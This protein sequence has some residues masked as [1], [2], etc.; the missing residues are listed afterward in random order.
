LWIE[1]SLKVLSKKLLLLI[2]PAFVVSLSWFLSNALM[3]PGGSVCNQDQFVY[4]Q[5]P[6]EMGFSF[7][8]FEVESTDK[9]KLSG[10]WIPRDGSTKTIIFSHGHGGDRHEGLRFLRALHEAG[11]SVIAFDYRGTGRSGGDFNS[12]TFYERQ[13]LHHIVSYAEAR[14]STSI[15]VHGFSQGGSIALF[16]MADDPRILAG[17]MEASFA[18]AKKVVSEAAFSRYFV[19]EFPLVDLAAYFF[20][21][22]TGVDLGKM[23]PVESISKI[24]AQ[25]LL[26]IHA[27]MDPFVPIHH[28]HDLLAAA[29]NSQSWLYDDNHHARAWQFDKDKAETLV[30]EHFKRWL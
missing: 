12:M 1:V 30:V 9:I 29:P 8:N 6:G 21:L 4:C 16:T 17:V 20:K 5:T 10:W 14:G 26:I 7:E 13:D 22:R 27:K 18:N 3:F 2:I 25:R 11:F 15:G 28:A 23:L 24:D 19:P